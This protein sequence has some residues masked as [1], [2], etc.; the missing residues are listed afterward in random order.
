MAVCQSSETRKNLTPNIQSPLFIN[1]KFM[2]REKLSDAYIY[3]NQ[4]FMLT[5]QV[6]KSF[7]S[8]FSLH[9]I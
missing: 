9:V 3:Y 2:A 1:K 4:E 7:K 5:T 6:H 8:L